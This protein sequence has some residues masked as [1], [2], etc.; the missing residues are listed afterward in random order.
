MKKNEVV[1]MHTFNVFKI[2]FPVVCIVRFIMQT[3]STAKLKNEFIQSLYTLHRNNINSCNGLGERA[4]RDIS[5]E[6][7]YLL[8]RYYINIIN[9]RIIGDR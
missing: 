8:G 6:P 7:F 3:F 2:N 9:I 4:A 1:S 5:F